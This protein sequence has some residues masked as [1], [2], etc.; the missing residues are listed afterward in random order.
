MFE[1]YEDEDD[2]NLE[3]EIEILGEAYENAYRLIT[4]K[5][6]L[7]DFL[8]ES[9]TKGRVVFL[10]FD[11]EAPETIDLILDDTIAYFEENEEYEKCQE[12]LKVKEIRNEDDT[13]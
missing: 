10:P 6:D 3:D 1:E 11:P 13:Q 8:I 5:I 12:L 2:F 4:K 7:A 9:T